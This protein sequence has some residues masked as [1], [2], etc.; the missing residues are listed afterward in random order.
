RDLVPEALLAQARTTVELVN[1]LEARLA[2]LAT[3]DALAGVSPVLVA[4]PEGEEGIVNLTGPP[5]GMING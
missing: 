3:V 1:N 4:W 5:S 2:Y